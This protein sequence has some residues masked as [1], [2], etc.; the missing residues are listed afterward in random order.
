MTEL[1]Y[2]RNIV[3][4]TREYS[5]EDIA[6]MEEM[7]R[8]M[9]PVDTTIEM[10]RL[11]W[12]DDTMVAGAAMYMECI[13]LWGGVTRSG[14]MEEPHV[15]DFTEVIG[16]ISSDRNNPKELGAVMEMNIGDEVHYL[17]K[18]CLIH[19]P[20]GMKHCPLT[21][22]EVN[23]PVF[24]FTLAPIGNYGRTSGL[25]DPE[26]IRKTGFVP[27]AEPDGSGTKYGRYIITEPKMH[28]TPPP[29]GK[30]PP[31]LKADT[32][33]V[34]SL[35]DEASTGGFYTDFVWIWSGDMTMSPEAHSHDFDEM[36]GIIGFD[37]DNPRD[38]P[39]DIG[40]EVSI[41][42]GEEKHTLKQSSLIYIPKGVKHCPLD[43]KNIKKPVL[44]FTVANTL[45]WSIEKP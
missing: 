7:M 45:M 1:R 29:E 38:N 20:P 37:P 4:D 26:A 13:W 33:H 2:A 43:F 28:G 8:D 30:R 6:R 21:F 24:F 15:H 18:S 44:C 14:L 23:H 39:R 9:P 12:M 19:I 40:G 3:T 42:M 31:R 10:L 16:F 25:R 11:L 17:T 34:V 5:P 35:D 36:I 41:V 22:K 27:P 32:T